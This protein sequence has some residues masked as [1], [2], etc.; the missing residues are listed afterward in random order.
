M[1]KGVKHYGFGGLKVADGESVQGLPRVELPADFVR[2][3]DAA[4]ARK[5]GAPENVN[6]DSC[7][8]LEGSIADSESAVSEVTQGESSNATDSTVHSDGLLVEDEVIDQLLETAVR[9]VQKSLSSTSLDVSVKSVPVPIETGTA[10]DPIASKRE[11]ELAG[12]HAAI[13]NAVKRGSCGAD[14]LDIVAEAAKRPPPEP[15][16]PPD[17]PRD[18]KDRRKR[19]RSGC[20]RYVCRSNVP[21]SISSLINELKLTLTTDAIGLKLSEIFSALESHEDQPLKDTWWGVSNTRNIKTNKHFTYAS[22]H[23][24]SH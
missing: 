16:S 10:F 1:F 7:P 11:D 20:F 15:E 2:M 9:D 19:M 17:A 14:K 3:R 5:T 13:S 18:P 4:R 21:N 8:E 23:L 6:V 12:L 22:T 24:S